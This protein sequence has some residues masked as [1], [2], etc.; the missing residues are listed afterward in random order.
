MALGSVGAMR[1]RILAV[2]GA[3]GLIVAA[4]VVRSLLAGD[5]GGDDDGDRTAN[6]PV[7]ACTPDLRT[8]CAALEDDGL[9]RAAPSSLDLAAAAA[10]DDTVEGW[11]TWDP[12]PGVVNFDQRGAWVDVEALASAPLGVLTADGPGACG[13]V[14]AAWSCV[15]AAADAGLPV[16]VG[17][18]AS[19]QSLAR[20]HPVAAALVPADGGFADVSAL[21][22]RAVIDSTQV[23]QADYAAQVNTFLTQRGALRVVIGPVPALRAAATRQSTATVATPTPGA[24]LTVV[25]ATH[26]SPTRNQGAITA[27]HLLGSEAALTALEALGLTPGDGTPAPVARAGEVY[28]IREKV[29]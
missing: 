3:V 10:P 28:A 17:N 11:I 18:G 19:A 14:G 7:V 16:G 22:L 21:E 20:L 12:A 2:V 15:L 25:I 24:Q 23:R 4:L 5:D 26:G 13:A 6:V 8:V 27:D 9:I 29:G 1:E